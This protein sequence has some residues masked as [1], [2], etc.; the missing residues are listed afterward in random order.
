MNATTNTKTAVIGE[1][2]KSQLCAIKAAQVSLNFASIIW[3]MADSKDNCS[4]FSDTIHDSVVIDANWLREDAEQ[5]GEGA[6][7]L[8]LALD[9]EPLCNGW[10]D[11]DLLYVHPQ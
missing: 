9:A 11:F 3:T 7:L 8:V 10:R 6:Q 2:N 1:P 4:V 5:Y